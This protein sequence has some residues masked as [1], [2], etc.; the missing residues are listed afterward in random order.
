MISHS[1]LIRVLKYD[2]YTGVWTW[3]VK[4][5]DK[6]VVGSRAGCI[7]KTNGYRYIKIYKIRYASSAL[8]WFYVTAE[9]PNYLVDHKNLVKDDDSWFNFRLAT[10]SQNGANINVTSKSSTGIKG[11]RKYPNGRFSA[12]ITVDQ[13]YHHL[14]NFDTKEEAGS[15]YE[16][17]AKKYFGE[18]ARI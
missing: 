16:A 2:K 1:E 10:K 7:C 11:V 17:A 12:Q 13:K 18:F 9:W 3:L 6:V 14:G 4:V 8:A 5:S 15:A